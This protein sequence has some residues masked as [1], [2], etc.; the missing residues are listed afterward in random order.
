MGANGSDAGARV[1]VRIVTTDA[2]LGARIAGRI[3]ALDLRE[4][5]S[6]TIDDGDDG[7]DSAARSETLAQ[8]TVLDLGPGAVSRSTARA[9]LRARFPTVV[10]SDGDAAAQ[11]DLVRDGADLVLPRAELGEAFDRSL[12]SAVL[13]VDRHLG[14]TSGAGTLHALGAGS[15]GRSLN[16]TLADEDPEFVAETSEDYRQL[17]V[18]RIEEWGLEVD[19]AVASRARALAGQFAE[20]LAG[21]RDVVEFHV[22]IVRD[23]VHGASP[24]RCQVINN[25]AQSLLVEVL[26]HLAGAYRLRLAHG[27]AAQVR[28]ESDQVAS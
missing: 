15:V 17:V 14:A 21:P 2:A 13:R 8:L 9:L 22:A 11:A 1:A 6:V 18:Q 4:I 12:L 5:A 16:A 20:R 19:Y 3:G 27:L 26:G 10:L 7:D 28:E 23:L 25:A 24:R